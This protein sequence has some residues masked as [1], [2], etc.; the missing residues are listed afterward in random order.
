MQEQQNIWP[1]H[2][3]VDKRIVKILSGSTYTNFP[4]AIRELIVNSYDADAENVWVEIDLKKEII[5][6]RDDGKGMNE[7]DFAFYLRIAGKRRTLL[8]TVQQ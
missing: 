1:K 2:I 5:S 6:I 8:Q 3:T 4:S 7:D